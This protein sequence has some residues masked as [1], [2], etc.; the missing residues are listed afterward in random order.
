MFKIARMPKMLKLLRIFK[1]QKIM[2]KFEEHI[3]SDHVNLFLT[4]I[5]LMLKIV[6]IAHWIASFFFLVGNIEKDKHE[7]CW[8]RAAGI[9]DASITE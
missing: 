2:M 6:F 7:D 5:K 3:V 9:E 8:I 1:L 4:F